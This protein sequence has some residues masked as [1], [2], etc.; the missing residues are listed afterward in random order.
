MADKRHNYGNGVVP[1][2]E[3]GGIAPVAVSGVTEVAPL[4]VERKA[5][6][7]PTDRR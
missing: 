7:G 2:D 6:S 4:H 5:D 3:Y 1:V